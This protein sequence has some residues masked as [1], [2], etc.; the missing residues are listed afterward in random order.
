MMSWQPLLDGA[1]SHSTK[2]EE[3]E[4]NSN[5]FPDTLF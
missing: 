4:R 2:M 5:Q 3:D 1:N